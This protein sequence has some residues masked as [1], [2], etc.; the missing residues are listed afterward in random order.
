MAAAWFNAL[1]DPSRAVAVSAGT[2]PG[3]AVHPIVALAMSEV[4]ID[5]TRAA[6]RLLTEE[7]ATRASI[8]ITMGCG[9]ACPVVPG[10]RRDDWPIDDPKPLPIERVRVIRDEVRARVEQLARENGWA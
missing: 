6:P 1:V 8:L 5:L 7:L 9:E 3:G 10:V 4:G 2:Q